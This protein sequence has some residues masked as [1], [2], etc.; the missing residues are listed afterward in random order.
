MAFQF[1]EVHVYKGQQLVCKEKKVPP[2]LGVGPLKTDGSMYCEG[3]HQNGNIG[4][5]TVAEG[6]TMLGQASDNIKGKIP[7][8]ALLVKTFA[9]IKSFLKVD[10]LLVAK[11]IKA[12]IIYTKVLMARSKNFLIDHPTKEGVKLVHACL[13]G[14][15]NA[16]YFRGRVRN[17]TQ[18]YLPEYWT[19]L[20]D[21]TSI[22]V[23]LTPVG[24][25]QNVIVKRINDNVI[26]LQSNG[27]M[28]IDCYFHVFGTRV[29]ISRLVTEVDA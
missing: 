25:H 27:G 12:D 19:K 13:E 1:D 29:D 16:V 14:P 20:V 23:S 26:H 10:K 2:A 5:F 9:R 21:P 18:I 6:V 15:E 24:S 7:V 22:T 8:Y 28:P 4:D 17:K 11:G 3:P